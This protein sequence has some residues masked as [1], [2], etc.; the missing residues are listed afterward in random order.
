L[1]IFDVD[2][3]LSWWKPAFGEVNGKENVL[4]QS[5][6]QRSGPNI[7][8]AIKEILDIIEELVG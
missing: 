3:R 2:S 7:F 6:N 1:G 8:D 4:E 5:A